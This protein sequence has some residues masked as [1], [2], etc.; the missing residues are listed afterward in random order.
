M[1]EAR[2]LECFAPHLGRNRVELLQ[3]CL[4]VLLHSPQAPSTTLLAPQGNSSISIT[5]QPQARHLKR[6]N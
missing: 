2:V 4:L 1:R 5:L 6:N 3:K